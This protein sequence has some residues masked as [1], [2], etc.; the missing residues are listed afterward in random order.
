MLGAHVGP[1]KIIQYKNLSAGQPKFESVKKKT[2]LK[3]CYELPG[4]WPLVVAFGTFKKQRIICSFHLRWNHNFGPSSWM[5]Q[6]LPWMKSLQAQFSFCQ[7]L[8]LSTVSLSASAKNTR[9][10][11]ITCFDQDMTLCCWR[12]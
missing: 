10:D 3:H 8:M 4:F 6:Y 11:H 1:Q 5:M 7:P 2:F 9:R 12:A